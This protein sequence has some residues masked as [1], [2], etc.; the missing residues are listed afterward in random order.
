MNN[1]DE[2]K[3][4]NF[5]N[6]NDPLSPNQRSDEKPSFEDAYKA[7]E[8]IALEVAVADQQIIDLIR[9]KLHE[10]NVRFNSSVI[11]NVGTILG[12]FNHSPSLELLEECLK[13]FE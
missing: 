7:L 9:K 6:K 10:E 2:N 5:E 11:H 13:C 12:K 3:P 1:N 8:A 4:E